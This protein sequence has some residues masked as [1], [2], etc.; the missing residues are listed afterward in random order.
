MIK[1]LPNLKH[2]DA[3]KYSA[4]SVTTEMNGPA[5]LSHS[6]SPASLRSISPSPSETTAWVFEVKPNYC[7][8]TSP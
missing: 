2:D 3:Q 6:P 7:C 5:A 1:L 4:H 8:G